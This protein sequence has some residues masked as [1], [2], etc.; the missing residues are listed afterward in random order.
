VRP[1]RDKL[2]PGEWALLGLLDQRPAHGFALARAMAPDGEVGR[3]WAV[4]RTMVYSALD[5]LDRRALVQ[6]KATVA[7]D[8]GPRRT[9][10]EATPTGIAALSDWLQQP[11]ERV[12]DARSLLMLK[13]LFL[14]RRGQDVEPLL[15]RQAVVFTA[16]ARQLAA[17]AKAAAGFDRA[18]LLWRLHSTG[19]VIEFTDAMLT[20]PASLAPAPRTDVVSLDRG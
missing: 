11:V 18:L 9:I 3:I 14:T 8:C 7:S 19:A 6:P 4:R 5:H 16:Q 1:A 10:L 12:R 17:A 13:L 20:D 2:T 15:S